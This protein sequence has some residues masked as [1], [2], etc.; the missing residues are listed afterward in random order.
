MSGAALRR[1]SQQQ[2]TVA[3]LGRRAVRFEDVAAVGESELFV[4]VHV[5]G[6]QNKFVRLFVLRNGVLVCERSGPLNQQEEEHVT[7]LL[8]FARASGV[9]VED[10]YRVSEN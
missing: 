1:S 2:Q 8:C 9:R 4:Y 7:D 5:S 3:I 6:L 10:S